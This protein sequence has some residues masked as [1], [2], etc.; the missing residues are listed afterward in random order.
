M[1]ATADRPAYWQWRLTGAE[2]WYRD[3]LDLIVP[4]YGLPQ[5]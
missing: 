2:L 1:T 4:A 5:R 3:N